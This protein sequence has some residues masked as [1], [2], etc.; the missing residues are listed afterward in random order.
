MTWPC[1]RGVGG[2]ECGGA[3]GGGVEG[4]V[5]VQ[6]RSLVELVVHSSAV[7]HGRLDVH[8]TGLELPNELLLLPWRILAG[9]IYRLRAGV[10]GLRLSVDSG[11]VF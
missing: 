10:P 3:T 11:W 4:V 2:G 9:P 6:H 1:R 5:V 7:V 8:H